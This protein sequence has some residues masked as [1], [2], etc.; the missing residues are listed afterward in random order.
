MKIVR[1][2]LYQV[3]LP[4]TKPYWLSGGRLKFETLDSTFVK[5]EADEGLFGWG[6]GCPWGNT[7][8]PAHG[9]GI[10]AGIATLAPSLLG[11]DPCA[12]NAINQTM[13]VALPGHLYV[14][15]AVDMACW[16]TLGK[17]SGLPLWRL[18]GADR[19][20]PVAVNSSISTGSNEE[21]IALIREAYAEGYRTHSAKVGGSIPVVDI[22]RIE[23]IEAAL[24][25]DETVTYD[26]NRAWL[27]AVAVQVLNNVSLRGWVEQPCETLSQCAQVAQ[28]V[29]QPIMLDECLHTFQDH[30]DAWKLGACEGVKVKP[31][32]VG[33]LTKAKQI[34]DFGVSVGWQMH[35][36]DLGGSA[37]AD[38]AAIHL[39]SSTPKENRLASWLCHHHLAVDP[40]PGQGARNIDGFA[41]PPSAPGLG[42][43][44]DGGILGDP[45]SVF[46]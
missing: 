43:T 31:N 35:L 33:G 21:M 7:Y 32:R 11:Q 46:T 37:L 36:E 8:L 10:R 34:R 16:D 15:S 26:V 4:L 13:D 40:V 29:K 19:A 6:E 23:A 22:S 14:K 17:A 41:T 25:P 20:D 27:P 42:V 18:M 38:T 12:L 28:R 2:S 45:V 5:I 30:L 24:R 44:P 1:I 39:A 9:P 3:D